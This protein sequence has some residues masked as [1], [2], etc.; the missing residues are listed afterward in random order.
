MCCA[1]ALR[2]YSCAL[3]HGRG[4][5]RPAMNLEDTTI[6]VFVVMLR[7]CS[8]LIEEPLDPNKRYIFVE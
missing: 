8:F 4:E 1:A 5:Q 6:S 7:A 2:C 3:L